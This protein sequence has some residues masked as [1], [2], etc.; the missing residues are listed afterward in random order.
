MCPIWI[1]DFYI[2]HQHIL[3]PKKEE[4]PAYA[5]QQS[6]IQDNAHRWNIIPQSF[7]YLNFRL[8]FLILIIC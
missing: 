5:C 2:Q 3:C 8:F 7:H 6:L 4:S 1:N